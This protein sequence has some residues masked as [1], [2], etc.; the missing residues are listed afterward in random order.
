MSVINS[1]KPIRLSKEDHQRLAPKPFTEEEIKNIINA[2]P[3]VYSDDQQVQKLTALIHLQV[4]TGLAIR[5]AIQLERE[6]IKDGWLRIR[7]QKTNRPVIQRLAPNLHNELS[8][9]LN[10]NPRF[11]FWDGKTLPNSTTG[12][13]LK[14]L[15]KIMEHAKVYVKGNISHR[16]RDTAVDYW[17]GQGVSLTEIA[18]ALGDT[19]TIVQKHYADLASKR[20][21]ERLAK[22][23]VRS[24]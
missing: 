15:R 14:F 9:V 1:L 12:L 19:L 21:E 3:K 20:M 8:E 11:I 23:P 7:R 22:M 16:F 10:G 4:A 2:V 17:L 13:Y 18:A 24:F 5:D 6:N